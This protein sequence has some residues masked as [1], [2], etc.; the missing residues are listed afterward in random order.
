MYRARRA[1]LFLVTA[2]L[3]FSYWAPQIAAQTSTDSPSLFHRR[4]AGEGPE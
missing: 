4:G 1:S 3:V 2:A